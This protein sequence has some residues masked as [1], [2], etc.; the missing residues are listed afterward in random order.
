MVAHHAVGMPD[1]GCLSGDLF[2]VCSR[3]SGDP[4][5]VRQFRRVICGRLLDCLCDNARTLVVL[6]DQRAEGDQ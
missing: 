4:R 3:Q 6:F 5:A 2:K 1:A